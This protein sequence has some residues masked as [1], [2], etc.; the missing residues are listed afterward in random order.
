M[1]SD[2]G[3]EEVAVHV[4]PEF[5]SVN[6]TLGLVIVFVFTA[7]CSVVNSVPSVS[8]A[9]APMTNPSGKAKVT[10]DPEL[11][12]FVGV[13]PTVHVVAVACAWTLEP[14]KLTEVATDPALMITADEG[15]VVAVSSEV[16]TVK[17]AAA[18]VLA[19]GL[20]SPAMVMEA[21]VPPASAQL[22][23]MVNVI[24]LETVVPVVPLQAPLKPETE[25][26]T[27]DAGTVNAD[28]KAIEIVSPAE[29]AP[30]DDVE[31]PTVHALVA[32]ALPGLPV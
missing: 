30:L 29:R 1:V 23:V 32:P 15:L 9:P 8:R 20:M 26:T 16:F 6:V 10:L 2:N 4:P 27:G 21:A 28:G 24:T 22:P 14:L 31:Y 25:V 18:Y 3:Y 11:S 7:Q 19:A 12:V 13:N 5:N 17:P